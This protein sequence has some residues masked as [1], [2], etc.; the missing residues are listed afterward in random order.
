MKIIYD[1]GCKQIIDCGLTDYWGKKCYAS[2]ILGKFAG[3]L[4]QNKHYRKEKKALEKCGA[5]FTIPQKWL[6]VINFTPYM[7]AKIKKL[8]NV[9][10]DY[11]NYYFQVW[12]D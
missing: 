2:I 8:F 9:S 12:T 7:V 10:D 11:I 3:C 4:S 5:C 6:R 1:D